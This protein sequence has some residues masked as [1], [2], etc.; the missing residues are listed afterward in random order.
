MFLALNFLTELLEILKRNA[1]NLQFLQSHCGYEVLYLLAVVL[2]IS[3]CG[4]LF[5]LRISWF[6]WKTEEFILFQ[7]I[8]DCASCQILVEIS[9]LTNYFCRF[10]Y[11]SWTSLVSLC[12]PQ[13]S[14]WL[15]GNNTLISAVWFRHR[16]ENLCDMLFSVCLQLEM[17]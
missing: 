10:S 14:N 16:F 7:T 15:W 4:L 5:S 17:T 13:H 1:A 8:G 3:R 2:N 12:A 11:R 9:L 6:L